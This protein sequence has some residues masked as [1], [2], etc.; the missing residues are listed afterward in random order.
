[1]TS[2]SGWI[3]TCCLIVA[4]WQSKAQVNSNLDVRVTV[5]VQNPLTIDAVSIDSQKPLVVRNKKGE[6]ILPHTYKV[7]YSKAELRF[8]SAPSADSVVIEYSR[9][10]TFLTDSY[11][12]LDDALIVRNTGNLE[13]LYRLKQPR[14]DQD[15]TFFGGLNSS[16]ALSRGLT[17]GNNQ[18]T[19]LNSNLDLK[20]YGNLNENVTLRASIQ[21]ANI[22]IQDGGYSKRLDE[23]DQIFI[24]FESS[25]WRLRGGDI[26][27]T[28]Q[29]TEFANFS[30]RIQGISFNSQWHSNESEKQL[31]AS[32]ALAK[33]QFSRSQFR[34]IEGNQGPYKLKGENGELYVLIVS[35]SERIYINGILLER[36][37]DKDYTIDYNAGEILFTATL[38]ITSDMRI[39]ADYQYSD[40]N[41]TRFMTFNGG[42]YNS[43]NWRLKGTVFSESDLKNQPLQQNLTEV[44]QLYLSEAGDGPEGIFAPSEEM[45]PFDQNRILYKKITIDGQEVF[46]YSNNPDDELYTLK[47][48]NVGTNQ[49][50]YQL[51]STD[52][53]AYIYAYVAP[54]DGVP[55]GSFEP[56]VRLVAP[57]SL[58]LANIVGGY[59]VGPKSKIDFD[60][61]ASQYDQNLFSNIDD[62]DNN[63][64]AG[65][66]QFLHKF[67]KD[68]NPWQWQVKSAF[69]KVHNNFKSIEALYSIEFNRDWDLQDVSGTRQ[70]IRNYLTAIKDSTTAFT[71]GYESLNQGDHYNG[72]KHKFDAQ[73]TNNRLTS[74]TES[75][76]LSVNGLYQTR[77][78]RLYQRI[79]YIEDT[80]RAGI[81]LNA[82]DLKKQNSLTEDMSP[83][84][85]RF[86]HL[87]GYIGVGDSLGIHG[88]IGYR[89]HVNDSVYNGSIQK[90]NHASTVYINSTVIKSSVSQLSLF[91]NY[92]KQ[93][94]FAQDSDGEETLNARIQYRQNLFKK[95]IDW[96]TL[97]ET[98]SGQ[99]PQ[100]G[101]TFVEVE[102]GQG[103]Y[104]WID[105]NG[106]GIQELEEFEIAN[107]QDQGIY[108]RLFLP[109]QVF[110]KTQQQVF[111]QN[112][113]INPKLMTANT[114]GKLIQKF[115]NQTSFS[116]DR[117]AKRGINNFDFNI[118]D[119]ESADV[120]A[121]DLQLRNSLHF[122]R[123][124]QQHN[125]TYYY[126]RNQS[127]NLWSTGLIKNESERHQM[128]WIHQFHP[129]WVA[130]ISAEKEIVK[131]RSESFPGRNFELHTSSISPHLSYNFDASS[132]LNFIGEWRQTENQINAKESLNQQQLALSFSSAF[133]TS[134]TLNAELRYIK[135]DFT[136]QGNTPVAYQLL[137]GLQ[138]GENWTWSLVGQQK[139]TKTLDLNVNYFGRKSTDLKT[140]HTGTIQLR[141][142]F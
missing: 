31:F 85:N 5:A 89:F 62:N 14:L 53:I 25:Q 97:V 103:S 12:S 95:L 30:K 108:V 140:I 74:V 49:G 61:A 32:A 91:A 48:T 29:N 114:D 44:Q 107:F 111:R 121:L 16:G 4:V 58:R 75:S 125:S 135:N 42:A 106:N 99:L 66:L 130:N 59:Q 70:Y 76:V 2:F 52:A 27:I 36:G 50:N 18:N 124:E 40:R 45:T 100:Q 142:N 10:P 90:A 6:L 82:E 9:F 51:I 86:K 141:A 46:Q 67:S 80:W 28:H 123:D 117:K 79:E 35:G 47:F 127:Q 57:Q 8:L 21:D 23:F 134:S 88:T 7:D 96:Q 37:Q 112:F 54:I 128:R 43:D 68:D 1:M 11:Q 72:Q 94:A 119:W 138:T 84:S 69:Q 110:V 33:G 129:N 113:I 109:H 39:S 83:L 20:I 139:L 122:N 24:E 22:P 133:K 19:V 104:T 15:Q 63:G 77:F 73:W 131:R 34:G 78:L 136:G 126:I 137:E 60:L 116:L 87:D 81:I 102:P 92:R 105:Y 64:F 17:I 115:Y 132:Q 55:Q 3:C 118:T 98:S 93:T 65:N 13:R 38:P 41:Y 120:L 26:D 71:Y 101:Y 56:I